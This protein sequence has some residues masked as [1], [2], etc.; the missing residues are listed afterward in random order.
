MNFL[1]YFFSIIAIFEFMKVSIII[2]TLNEADNIGKL[3]DYL[4]KNSNDTLAEILVIDAQ[5][6]DNTEGVAR[7]A[8][9]KV[10]S[11]TERGRAIQM[12]YGASLAQGDILYFIHADC[13]PPKTYLIDI[14]Q[15]VKE[16]FEL[17]CYRYKFDNDCFMLKIN[18]FFTRF[19]PLWC[20]GGDETLFIKKTVFDSLGGFD[21]K[22]I[23]ME[24]YDF[25][26]RAKALYSMKI[27]PKYATVSARKYETN[28]WWQVQIANLTAFRMYKKGIEPREIAVTYKQMLN[29]R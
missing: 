6:S 17:G 27:I 12:N 11:T 13:F 29:Y 20:R 8:G 2:P 14:Q 21:E 3:I 19:E 25:I 16:G 22:Y 5:S 1:Y 23:I 10:V 4:F 28:S 24:E 26:R 18:A 7:K 15:I 9:A